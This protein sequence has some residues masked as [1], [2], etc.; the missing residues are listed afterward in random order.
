MGW[1]NVAVGFFAIDTLAA[2]LGGLVDTTEGGVVST[3]PKSLASGFPASPT[4]LAASALP[5]SPFR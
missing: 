5:A 3:A 2:P 4:S 1:L